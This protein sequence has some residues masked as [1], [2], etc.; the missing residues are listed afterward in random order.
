LSPST[1]AKPTSLTVMIKSPDDPRARGGWLWIVKNPATNR[2]TVM[3]NQFCITC[4][5]NANESH[6][7][8]DKNPNREFRDYVFFVYEET[9]GDAR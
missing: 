9:P 8:G 4:H 1:D 5:A 7:Y 6:P 2:E 3:R